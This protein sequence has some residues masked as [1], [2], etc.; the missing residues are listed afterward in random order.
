MNRNESFRVHG[1][2]NKLTY[3]C[4]RIQR[5]PLAKICL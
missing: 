2:S 1:L 5:K 3:G 4:L